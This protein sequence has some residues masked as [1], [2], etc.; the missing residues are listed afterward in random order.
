MRF[1]N[2]LPVFKQSY[3]KAELLSA[4]LSSKACIWYD[5]C[6]LSRWSYTGTSVQTTCCRSAPE[7]VR[8]WRGRSLPACPDSPACWGL[9]GRICC[10]P[11]R[12]SE[13]LDA[14]YTPAVSGAARELLKHPH[15]AK[16][17][18]S[19]NN[20]ITPLTSLNGFIHVLIQIQRRAWMQIISCTN[21][22][23]L[24]FSSG[25]KHVVWKGSALAALHCGRPPEP[26]IIYGSPPNIGEGK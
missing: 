11:P 10:A 26:P 23:S 21:A 25:C 24:L 19:G 16:A 20:C 17:T 7:F 13:M 3:C 18:Q 9:A 5:C 14:I 22:F 2:F 8:C 6:L 12:V 15:Y 1:F 4:L